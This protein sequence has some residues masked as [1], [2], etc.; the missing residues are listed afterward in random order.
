MNK[1]PF[2]KT[3]SWKCHWKYIFATTPMCTYLQNTPCSVPCGFGEWELVSKQD[4]FTVFYNKDND[5][6]KVEYA[7]E[8]DKKVCMF[9]AINNI[10]NK[11]GND[12]EI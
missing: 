8:Q 5:M 3:D 12:G 11:E 4:N 10:N 1:C 7:N 6:Y 9:S 2:G